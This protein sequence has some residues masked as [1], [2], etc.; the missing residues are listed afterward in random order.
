MARRNAW[1]WEHW[2][3]RVCNDSKLE[4]E[5]QVWRIEGFKSVEY[6]VARHGSRAYQPSVQSRQCCVQNSR[7]PFLDGH[8][9]S[10]GLGQGVY[11]VI[12]RCLNVAAF[13][14]QGSV[15]RRDCAEDPACS[16]EK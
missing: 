15:Y 4:R 7:G 1:F 9:L 16:V 11:S 6:S 10:R 8:C 2:Q 5:E 13:V 3:V 12:L 14:T